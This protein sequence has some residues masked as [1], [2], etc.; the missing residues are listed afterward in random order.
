MPRLRTVNQSLVS[1]PSS[2]EASARFH[3]RSDRWAAREGWPLDFFKSSCAC[4]PTIFEEVKKQPSE[5]ATEGGGG[6]AGINVSPSVKTVTRGSSLRSPI[7]VS[8]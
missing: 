2:P 5:M 3:R 8:S 6:K 1:C 7:S 4:A